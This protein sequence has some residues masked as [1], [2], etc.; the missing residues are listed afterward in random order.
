MPLPNWVVPAI[1]GV[2]G[3]GQGLIQQNAQKNENMRIAQFQAQAN[4]RYLR[5]QQ[6]Y[7]SPENQMARF[8]EAG[9]NPNLV[10]GQGN[11]GNQ[12]APLS[13]PDV[14]PRDF[15]SLMNMAQLFNQTKMVESQVA[16]QNANTIKSAAQ[17]ELARLQSL[18]LQK[19]PLLNS[20]AYNAIISS[21][22]SSAD[23]KASESKIKGQEA[24]WK[25][26]SIEITGQAGDFYKGSQGA[27]K[28]DQELKLL[29]QRYHLGTVDQKIKAEIL[30]SK[31][32]Q[33]SILEVQKRFMTDGDITP[34]HIVTFIQMLLMKLL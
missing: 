20:T 6:E 14:K 25:T 21:L 18:V 34:Q 28:M 4:E 8:Q 5:E 29:E 30:E 32:F 33:N 22:I 16:A 12:S 3:L 2:V 10:Y 7:N 27:L 1:T 26:K 13:S 11:P 17:S 24:D 23:V 31:D 19:N 15:S 9:L